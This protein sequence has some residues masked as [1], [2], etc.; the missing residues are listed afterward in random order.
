RT[1]RTVPDREAAIAA[2]I[3]GE[4]MHG[5]RIRLLDVADPEAFEDAVRSSASEI[6]P[7]E[8]ILP[9]GDRPQETRLA[10]KALTDVAEPIPLP[11]GAPYGAI[12]IDEAA[13]TLCL[14]CVSLCPPAALG[15]NPDKPMVRFQETACVQCGLCETACPENAITL[16]PRLNLEN[17]AMDWVVLNEEEP[18]ACI[19]CGK[20]FGVKSTIEKIVA[21]LED[22]HWMFK[23]S[24]NTKLIQMCDD[25]RV[26][27]QYHSDASPFRMGA[28]PMVRTTADELRE[29]ELETNKKAN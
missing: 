21:T 23:G 1:D 13:C 11:E 20:E 16:E 29:R 25:C 27:A 9:L 10:A 5:G 18:F 19:S 7:A 2:A 15:D 8:P 26:R 17:A 28:R 12:A 14:A 4:S 3:L 6:A 22:K 24:D